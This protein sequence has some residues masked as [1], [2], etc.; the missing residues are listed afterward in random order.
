MRQRYAAKQRW[1]CQVARCAL[2]E[3]VTTSNAAIK[4][5]APP[6]AAAVRPALVDTM[7]RYNIPAR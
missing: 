2:D 6:G 3:P 5:A 1:V 7:R 4:I